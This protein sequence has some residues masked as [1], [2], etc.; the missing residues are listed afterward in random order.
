MLFQP[1]VELSTGRIAGFE[2]LARF[3][4][5]VFRPPD[6][7]FTEAFD[8]GLGLDLELHAVSRA[9][10]AVPVLP[11]GTYLAVNVSASTAMCPDLERLVAGAREARIVVELT[12][13]TMVDDYDALQGSLDRLRSHGA[14]IAVDD[15]GTGYAGLQHILR[16]RPDVVK[17]DRELITGID[18][19]PA[20]HALVAAM[21]FFALEIGALLVAEGIE[22]EPELEAV[23][24]LGVTWG[25][26]FFLAPPAPA[27]IPHTISVATRSVP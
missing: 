2:S 21:T 8:V 16:L 27:G 24:R 10:A 17:L 20:R 6:A 14:L 7:W 5:P 22:T 19:D 26:G 9:F 4:H 12:E 15:A 25:Q 23:R 3:H 13:H 18:R 1:I 11:D